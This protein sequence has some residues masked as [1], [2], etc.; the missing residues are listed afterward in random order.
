M[1]EDYD[2]WWFWALVVLASFWWGNIWNSQWRFSI[3][4]QVP[5]Q[6]AVVQKEPPSC[7]FWTAPM[8]RKNCPYDKVVHKV[9]MAMSKN[10]NMPVMSPDEGDTWEPFTPE[11]GVQV[12]Q[13][14]KVVSVWV[15]WNK[16]AD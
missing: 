4:Y 2:G 6:N 9:Q 1:K 16:V 3:F 7:D 8:G 12:P 10:G 11:P 14:R 15:G 13:Y 5:L